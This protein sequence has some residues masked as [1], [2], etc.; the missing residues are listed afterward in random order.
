MSFP[1]TADILNWPENDD[2]VV[3]LRVAARFAHQ[4]TAGTRVA[5]RFMRVA[6]EFSNEKAL[7][8]YLK[9]HPDADK[10]KHKVVK[11]DAKE[12][13]GD[14]E[15]GHDDE[16]EGGEHGEEK[17][18]LT[19]KERLKSLS[20]K[21]KSFVKSA[22]KEVKKFIEDPEHRRK[23]L[24]AA[25]KTLTEAPEKLAKRAIKTVKEEVH[26][27]KEASAGVKAVLTGGKM[28]K[29]QKKA[30]KTVAFHVA[31]TAAATLLTT[32]GGPL[33][34]AGAFGKSMAKHIAMK[35][36]S[37]ALGHVHI[38]EEFGHVGHG[39]AHIMD[40]LAADEEKKP[41]GKGKKADPEMA[42]ANLALAALA[43]QLEKLDDHESM[44]EVLEAMEDD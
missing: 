18:K 9:E 27:W 32:T 31:L 28:T 42:L 5:A 2:R 23:A 40:K 43:K 14:K 7:R 15:K 44:A 41:K 17:P 30:V 35:A 12:H 26:E 4:T 8:E 11:P 3:A 22:P 24:M 6:I 20:D 21:A 19:W 36:A 10:S 25:H 13:G 38:L 29:H 33:V 16:G 1:K 34:A 37:Q 39:V